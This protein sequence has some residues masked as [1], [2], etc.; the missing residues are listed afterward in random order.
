M[1]GMHVQRMHVPVVVMFLS[2]VDRRDYADLAIAGTISLSVDADELGDRRALVEMVSVVSVVS[3]VSM[4]SMV[5]FGLWG[6]CYP[7]HG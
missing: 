4:V 1:Y 6:E 2:P 7:T 5:M 3:M